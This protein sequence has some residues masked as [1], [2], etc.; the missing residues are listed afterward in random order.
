[1]FASTFRASEPKSNMQLSEPHSSCMIIRLTQEVEG[2]GNLFLSTRR[3]RQH[4]YCTCHDSICAKLPGSGV[5]RWHHHGR[6]RDH[7]SDRVMVARIDSIDL[8]AAI[9]TIPNRQHATFIR[10]RCSL[11]W[12]VPLFREGDPCRTGRFSSDWKTSWLDSGIGVL[13]VG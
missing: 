13:K 9:Q 4:Q 10:Y 3:F 12:P 1:M 5:S 2:A 7:S 8:A 11:G 6:N